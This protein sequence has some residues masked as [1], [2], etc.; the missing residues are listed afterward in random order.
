MEINGN[1]CRVFFK[2]HES[3]KVQIIEDDGKFY[4]T[5]IISR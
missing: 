4:F 5:F 1:Y 2:P 3:A